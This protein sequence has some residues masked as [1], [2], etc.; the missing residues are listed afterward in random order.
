MGGDEVRTLIIAQAGNA[1]PS[2]AE[3]LSVATTTAWALRQ[4]EALVMKTNIEEPRNDT[5]IVPEVTE[6]VAESTS[7]VPMGADGATGFYAVP[8]GAN[9]PLN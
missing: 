3:T 2:S 1:H 8:V 7:S 6:D 4:R 9:R 5:T